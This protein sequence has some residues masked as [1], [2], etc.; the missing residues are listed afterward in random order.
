MTD[1]IHR[2]PPGVSTGSRPASNAAINAAAGSPADPATGSPADAAFTRPV[3]LPTGR[4]LAGIAAACGT[5]GILWTTGSL[6]FGFGPTAVT[7]G[8]ASVGVVATVSALAL[9]ALTP[10]RPRSLGTW[11]MVWTAAGFGRLVVALGGAALLYSRPQFGPAHVFPP[12]LL[13]YVAVMVV[14][15]MTY[16]RAMAAHGPRPGTLSADSSSPQSTVGPLDQ[17]TSE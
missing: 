4:F 3:T 2:D 13:A 6:A 11:P 15:T 16:A 9:L 17:T 8:L 5:V 1:S 7:A 12:V 10:W 14:E